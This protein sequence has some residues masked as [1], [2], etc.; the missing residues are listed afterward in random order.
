MKGCLTNMVISQN[1]ILKRMSLI[2]KYMSITRMQF[3]KNIL[4]IYNKYALD[5]ASYYHIYKMV[6]LCNHDCSKNI[7][8]AQIIEHDNLFIVI[9][10]H[11]E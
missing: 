10:V 9:Y 6:T 5:E 4:K 7:C 3:K 11:H 1:I 8:I 2:C